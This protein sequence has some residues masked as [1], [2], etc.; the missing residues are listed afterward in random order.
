MTMGNVR[1][2]GG[3]REKITAAT[4][5][6]CGLCCVSLHDQ[7]TYC[8]ITAKD[9]ERLGKKFVR[10]HVLYPRP[11]DSLY[12]AMDGG[13]RMYGA[14]KTAWVE[15]TRG[16]FKG[17]ATCECVALKGSLLERTRCGVYDKR[18]EVCRK[19]VR[20]GDSACRESRKMVKKMLEEL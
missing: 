2:Q 16:P 18:P 1:A 13:P 14:I 3:P 8:D 17:V 7:Q 4:C 15:H 5:L 9:E 19:S 11:F 10:L 12:V 6:E 20:P